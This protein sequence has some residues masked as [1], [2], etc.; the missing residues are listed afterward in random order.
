MKF[1][2]FCPTGRKMQFWN[3]RNT[4]FQLKKKIL[5]LPGNFSRLVLDFLLIEVEF[6]RI[7]LGGAWSTVQSCLFKL[8]FFT[9]KKNR[10]TMDLQWCHR[11]RPFVKTPRAQLFLSPMIPKLKTWKTP[12]VF[13]RVFPCDIIDGPE[14]TYV[15]S[16]GNGCFR[17]LQNQIHV[18]C[19]DT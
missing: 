4:V 13:P 14:S 11:E 6:K 17:E 1:T 18:C 8:V 19:W 9:I 15:T 5:Q 2:Y 10:Y 12:R 7:I 16:N 3:G